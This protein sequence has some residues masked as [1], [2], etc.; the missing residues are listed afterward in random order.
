MTVSNR[1]LNWRDD[2]LCFRGREYARIVPD[3]SYPSMWRVQTRDGRL[4]DMVNRTRARDAARGIVLAI[5]NGQETAPEAAPMRVSGP[6]AP[7]LPPD[8]DEAISEATTA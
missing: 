3:A 5:L 1:T 7:S 2:K 8:P 4:S 6:G